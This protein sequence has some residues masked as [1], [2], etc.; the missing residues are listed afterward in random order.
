MVPKP[1]R[2]V[3]VAEASVIVVALIAPP[4]I[5]I[6]LTVPLLPAALTVKVVTLSV[7][8]PTANVAPGPPLLEPSLIVNEVKT[9][10]LATSRVTVYA[11]APPLPPSVTVSPIAGTVPVDQFVARLQFPDVG[12]FVDPA[13][14]PFQLGLANTPA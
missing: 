4:A 6:P 1:A 3:C 12:A 7:F 8:P 2:L 13:P 9:G 14:G 10:V 11:S 5:V